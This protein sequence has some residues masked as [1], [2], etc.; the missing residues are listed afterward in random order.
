M[1]RLFLILFLV[2]V[3]GSIF[4]QTQYEMNKKANESYWIADKELNEI[5]QKILKEYHSDTIFVKNLK[6]AQ[7]IWITFRD[8]E[9]NLKYP[10]KQ[11]GFYGSI[12]PVC[13]AGYLEKLTR[14]RIETL[15][16][17]LEGI[18]EGDACNGSVK[19]KN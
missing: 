5:Y 16:I 17:W 4:S 11:T 3:Y 2:F 8:A 19:F 1:K 18:P 13:V 6:A 10:K 12:H 7:R 15:K 9:L 14:Q